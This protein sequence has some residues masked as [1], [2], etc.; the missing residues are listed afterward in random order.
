M[1]KEGSKPGKVE[2]EI[3]KC[4]DEFPYRQA[5]GALMYLMTGTRPDIAYAVGHASRVLE[6]PSKAD[7]IKVKRIFRYLAG[8]VTH[9]IVYRAGYKVGNLESYSD[10]DH[11]GDQTTGRSTTGVVCIY[12]GGSISW[13]SQRQ[14]SVAIS[15]TEAEV[16]A[17]SEGAREM[18][19]LK[20]LFNEIVGIREVPTLQI[21]N[22][23][24]TRLAENPELHRRTKHIAIRHFYVRECVTESEIKVKRVDTEAQIADILTKPL[25]GPRHRVLCK[26]MGL[27]SD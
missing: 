26:E 11:G 5:V 4:E 13:L 9:G 2:Q 15:S 17:A 20:R 23:A 19:W 22:E 14:T 12:G 1:V 8:T 21:D 24:A 25:P 27:R 16:V 3:E 18:V 7:W 10:A 6:N